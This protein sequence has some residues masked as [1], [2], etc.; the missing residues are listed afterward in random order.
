MYKLNDENNWVFSDGNQSIVLTSKVSDRGRCVIAAKDYHRGDV[1]L[2]ESP[3]AMVVS[4]SLTESRCS[5]CCTIPQTQIFGISADDPKRYCSPICLNNDL[6]F[7]QAE[8]EASQRLREL[9]IEGG[10]DACKLI[11]RIAAI[12][13]FENRCAETPQFPLIG[14]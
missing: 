9:Q 1:I 4:H 10:I 14:R 12:R 5:F 6:K 2:M 11:I 3:Y 7:H 8:S 13:S